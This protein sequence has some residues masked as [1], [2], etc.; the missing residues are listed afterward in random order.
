MK[1]NK[2]RALV[3]FNTGTRVHPASKGKGSYDRKV[4]D[5]DGTV[6]DEETY[7]TVR[8][9]M[10]KGTAT[11]IRLEHKVANFTQL[12]EEL[13]QFGEMCPQALPLVGIGYGP[14]PTGRPVNFAHDVG[15]ADLMA[16]YRELE[17]L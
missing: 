7:Y 3:P 8:H 15:D 10:H 14:K 12:A 11:T 13:A 2:P 16:Q 17:K 9:G 1:S 6:M 4:I 5:H